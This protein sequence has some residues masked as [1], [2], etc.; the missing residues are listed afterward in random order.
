ML[1]EKLCI[2]SEIKERL[3]EIIPPIIS[4]TVIKKFRKIVKINLPLVE[5]NI[6]PLICE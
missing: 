3:P 2:A 1:S 4:P 6:S 5:E